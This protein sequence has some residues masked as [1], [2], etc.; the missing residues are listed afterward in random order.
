ML[1]CL[2]DVATAG[3]TVADDGER[4]IG[5]RLSIRR[6]RAEQILDWV[7]APLFGDEHAAA[8]R[9]TGDSDA[10]EGVV[11]VDYSFDFGD[12]T[13]LGSDCFVIP[14][15]ARTVE[16]SCADGLELREA[17]SILLAEWN[18]L[19]ATLSGM[20]LP[21]GGRFDRETNEVVDEADLEKRMLALRLLLEAGADMDKARTD[22][23]WTPL[24][25]AAQNGHVEVVR[26][27]VEAGA[28][29][30]KADVD[31]WTPLWVAA[32]HGNVEMVRCLVEAG[33]DKDKARTDIMTTPL[34]MAAQNGHVAVESIVLVQD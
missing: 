12:R 26:C 15:G 11:W 23:R 34:L 16:W 32:L 1:G 19:P 24:F 10:V 33:A 30:D 21:G 17:Q 5:I 2:R 9:A 25:M 4:R 18:F 22:T 3:A 28:D 8:I 27:L 20:V 13:N 7:V 29:K 6:L 31:G 14:P